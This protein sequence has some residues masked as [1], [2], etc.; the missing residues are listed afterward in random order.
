[1]FSLVQEFD[2][3]AARNAGYKALLLIRNEEKKLHYLKV[4]GMKIEFFL[5]MIPSG[6]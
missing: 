6:I 1:M 3:L 5:L 2:Y 4:S